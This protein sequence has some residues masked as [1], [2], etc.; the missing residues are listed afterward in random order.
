MSR[1]PLRT[2]TDKG[3]NSLKVILSYV[4]FPLPFDADGYRNFNHER[5]VILCRAARAARVIYEETF[6]WAHLRL[7]FG[8]PLI[9][10][11][12]VR[13]KFANMIS[14]LDQGQAWLEEV[15]YQSEFPFPFSNELC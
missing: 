4:T 10:Q 11:P 9:D 1:L 13:A 8:K 7:V 14:K 5:L 6:R 2:R 12:V 15:T 3:V